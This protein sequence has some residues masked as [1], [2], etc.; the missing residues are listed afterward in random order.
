MSP[1]SQR[2]AASVEH[3]GLCLLVALIAAAGIASVAAGPLDGGRELGAAIA[4]KLRC[5]PR[6]PGP[7]WRDPLT[8]AYGRAL[9][10]LVRAL[11]PTPSARSGLMAVDFRYCRAASCA[12]PG[13]GPRLTAS[14]RRTTAFVA[15][16]DH[17]AGGGG[18]E[19]H[20]W[21]YR[22]TLGWER[23][24][25]RASAADVAEL[26]STP[27]L[28]SQDPKLVPL[29]TLAGRNHFDFLAGEEPPWRWRIDS[30]W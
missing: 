25:R 10:G 16:D 11:A 17:R 27:L 8:E 26:A 24:T 23:M 13:D 22:P 19:V 18:V 30:D 1:A 5:A 14:N 21:L 4:R 28:E 6:L 7:C 20:F 12:A 9:G 2:G 15:L 3:V 29:E